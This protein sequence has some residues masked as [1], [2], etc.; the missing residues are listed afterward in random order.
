MDFNTKALKDSFPALKKSLYFNTGSEGLFPRN[1]YKV[2]HRHLNRVFK[3]GGSHPD[4][5]KFINL[6]NEKLKLIIEEMGVNYND[7]IKV[8]SI[9]EGLNFSFNMFPFKK[10][11]KILLLKNEFKTVV[12]AAICCVKKYEC[13][14]IWADSIEHAQKIITEQKIHA[15][16]VSHVSYIDGK[17]NDIKGLYSLCKEKDVFFIVDGAQ[18]IGNI[19]WNLKSVVNCSDMYVW[20]T[21]KWFLSPRGL[22]FIIPSQNALQKCSPVCL[23][24]FAT[25][26]FETPDNISFTGNIS[27]M[28]NHANNFNG[29]IGFVQTYK[30][31]KK[32]IGFDNALKQNNSNKEYFLKMAKENNIEIK[33]TDSFL[34]AFKS[35]KYTNEQIVDKFYRHGIIIRTIPNTEFVRVS[36]HIY[37]NRSMINSFFKIW[38]K[39]HKIN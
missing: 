36:I 2:L 10:N 11:D 30:F 18:S 20:T 15:F 38:K 12:L 5:F 32:K 24:Y 26:T 39:I 6:Y 31:I 34:L 7:T 9:S 28:S 22:A 8:A 16:A 25:K 3:Y 23:N 29:E 27:D 4:Y 33:N 35:S 1:T 13:E 14:I 17:V 37:I 19:T 21:H